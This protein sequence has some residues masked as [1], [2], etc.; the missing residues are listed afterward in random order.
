M[1]GKIRNRKKKKGFTLIELIVVIAIL[2]ILAAIAVPRL[3]G[4]QDR[5]R[6]QADVQVAAQVRSST[7]LLFANRELIVSTSPLIFSVS[8]GANA[9]AAPVLKIT[10]GA[11]S[12]PA[13]EDALRDQ[14][15]GSATVQGL[16]SDFNLQN[17]SGSIIWVRVTTDGQVNTVLRATKPADDNQWTN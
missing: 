7:A 12:A 15:F 16:V 6:A 17:S 2:G 10:D 3:I 5:A 8:N 11:I 4:F 13:D 9:N 14:L 1:M